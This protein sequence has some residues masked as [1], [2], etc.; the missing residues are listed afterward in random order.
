MYGHPEEMVYFTDIGCIIRNAIIN[1]RFVVCV[2]GKD[3]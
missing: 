1:L 3:S 2:V